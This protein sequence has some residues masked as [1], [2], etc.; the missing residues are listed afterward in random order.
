MVYILLI[1]RY[2]KFWILLSLLS[3]K[4]I[5]IISVKMSFQPQKEH[6]DVE[7]LFASFSLKMH[8]CFA[9]VLGWTSYI[10]SWR[11]FWNSLISGK[12]KKF[13]SLL[14]CT[15]YKFSLRRYIFL[16]SVVKVNEKSMLMKLSHAIKLIS[17]CTD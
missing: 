7:T 3:I 15:V 16:F 6:S 8:W 11:S 2:W 17:T 13:F 4:H 1:F 14:S 12:K 5:C 10:R 9:S